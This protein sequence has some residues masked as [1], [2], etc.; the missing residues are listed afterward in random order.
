M[1]ELREDNGLSQEQ[2]ARAL[3]YK[4]SVT[5]VQWEKGTRTP[6]LENLILIADYFNVTLDEL[7]GRVQ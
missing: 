1:K 2:L 4:S 7:V 3:G 6:G 5:I